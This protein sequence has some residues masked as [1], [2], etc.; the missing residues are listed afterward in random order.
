V[1]APGLQVSRSVGDADLKGQGVSAEAE[2]AELALMPHDSFII[3]ATDGLWDRVR[4]GA[5]TA[6]PGGRDCFDCGPR[7]QCEPA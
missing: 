2:T 3:A 6:G 7:A 4:C 5:G 1:G